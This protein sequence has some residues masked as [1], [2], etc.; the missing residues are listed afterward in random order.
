MGVPPN[1]PIHSRIFHEI[2]YLAIEIPPFMEPPSNLTQLLKI[3]HFES[4]YLVNILNMAIFHNYVSLPEG[5]SHQ[6]NQLTYH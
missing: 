1:H 4:T 5:K 6:K 2:N 3:A